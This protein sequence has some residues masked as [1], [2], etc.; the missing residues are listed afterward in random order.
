M[1]LLHLG[2]GD[3]IREGFD[4]LDARTGW[5]FEDGLSAYAS[6]SIAGITISH[7]LMYVS[8][9]DW[10]DV[11]REFN[12]VLVQFGCVRITEDDCESPTSPRSM[13]PWTGFVS[14]TGPVAIGH[15]LTAAGFASHVC[16]ANETHF[17]DDSL[18]IA[19]RE[20]KRPYYVFYIEGIK[21]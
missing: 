17:I 18:L 1:K 13:Q 16:K 6:G 12:R 7:A 15:F 4:N 14:R 8:V 21:R 3:D 10:Y 11:F 20:D 19:H 9:D 5:R 2:C